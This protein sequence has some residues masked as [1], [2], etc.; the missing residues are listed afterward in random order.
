VKLSGLLS[1]KEEE[2]EA[3]KETVERECWERNNLIAELSRRPK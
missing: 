2:I 1:S 3:L